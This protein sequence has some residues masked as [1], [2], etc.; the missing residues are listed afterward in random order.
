MNAPPPNLAISGP[1]TVC[2]QATYSAPA[3]AGPNQAQTYTWTASPASAF[4]VAGGAGATF[5]TANSGSS[6][7]YG[8]LTLTL[9]GDCPLTLTKQ[10]KLGAP[11]APTVQQLDPLDGCTNFAARFQVTNFDPAL[12]YTTSYTG[13]VRILGGINPDD[14]TFSVKGGGSGGTVSI[15]AINSCGSAVSQLS[16][17]F[18][19]CRNARYTLSPNP[20]ATEVQVQQLPAAGSAQLPTGAATSAAGSSEPGME[21]VRIYDNYGALRLEQPGQN[22]K[23]V[24]LAVG[25]LPA[26][27]YVVHIVSGGT[28]VSRQQLLI[29]R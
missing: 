11:A 23:L 10:V 9:G 18:G 13:S 5:T 25:K 27:V 15:T 12:Q 8:T 4:T 19:P 16:F 29:T 14:G 28:V 20:A 17:R 24:R 26:G 6:S 21:L 3:V 2:G 1:G 22:A 7:G